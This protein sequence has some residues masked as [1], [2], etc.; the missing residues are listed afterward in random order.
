MSC[1]AD[2][3]VPC[4]SAISLFELSSRLMRFSSVLSLMEIVGRVWRGLK[5]LQ[6]LPRHGGERASSLLRPQVMRGIVTRMFA[7]CM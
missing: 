2:S 6:D 5:C 3:V 7:G 4:A 1:V